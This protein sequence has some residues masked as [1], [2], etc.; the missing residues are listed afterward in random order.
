MTI[1]SSLQRILAHKASEISQQKQALPTS[2][3]LDRIRSIAPAQDVVSALGGFSAATLRSNII[4]EI[5]Q[6]SPSRGV[7]RPNL[8]AVL[9]ANSYAAAGAAM[10]SVLTDE[11]FFGGSFERLEAVRTH[12]PTPLLC[13][14]F[15]IDPW[16]V[17]RAR[18]AGADAVL[19]IVSAMAER[20]L[21]DL[22]QAILD[23]GMTPL[24]EIH[25]AAELEVALRLGARCVGVNNRNLHSF[26]TDL[27]VSLTLGP[28][29][30]TDVIAISESGIQTR[31]HIQLLESAGYRAFLVGESLVAAD[32][33]AAHLRYLGGAG[34]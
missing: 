27:N 33:P 22:F 25:D 5:K 34:E 1:P 26:E 8:D 7:I 18:A 4:A 17:H 31:E 9:L 6:Q 24:V 20:D 2:L 16:Q 19:L 12:V 14:E 10:I 32:D 13:K 23:H 28:H 3:L 30:P 15:V 11:R 29:I 21:G